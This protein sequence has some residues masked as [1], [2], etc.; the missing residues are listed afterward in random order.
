MQYQIF[1]TKAE[2]H[3]PNILSLSVNRTEA[4]RLDHRFL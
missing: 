2:E 4:K 1:K 3:K